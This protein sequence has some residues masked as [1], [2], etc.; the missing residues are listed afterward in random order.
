[1]S[2]DGDSRGF[3]AAATGAPAGDES[4]RERS[5]PIVSQ[6]TRLRA[7]IWLIVGLIFCAVV[8]N[9]VHKPNVE[10]ALTA[11]VEGFS[12]RATDSLSTES[13]PVSAAQLQAADSIILEERAVGLRPGGAVTLTAP[14]NRLSV[15]ELTIPKGW[16]IALATGDRSHL[17]L[18]ATPPD[19]S[20]AV[21]RAILT[22]ISGKGTTLAYTSA[23][24]GETEMVAVPDGTPVLVSAS[25][26]ALELNVVEAEIFSSVQISDLSLARDSKTTDNSGH[27][28]VQVEGAVISGTLWR[29]NESGPS[30]DLGPLDLLVARNIDDG[31][32]RRVTWHDGQLSLSSH[33]TAKRLENSIG[34]AAAD[35]RPVWLD[36]FQDIGLLKVIFGIITFIGGLELSAFIRSR[37]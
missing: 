15:S 28:T 13:M 24:S 12:F 30:R 37:K 32:L 10:Y 11:Q 4:N 25:D 20:P 1:M 35:L 36:V 21:E 6:L 19:S 9:F 23:L 31:V 2:V 27:Q 8:L 5:G 18:S 16:R 17:L 22:F 3:D 7:A 33:G 34:N 29:E 26:V 14:G